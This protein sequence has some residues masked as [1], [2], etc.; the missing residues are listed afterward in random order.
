MSGPGTRDV[1]IGWPSTDL[2]GMQVIAENPLTIS[3]SAVG[4]TNAGFTAPEIARAQHMMVYFESGAIRFR[5]DGTAVT[6]TTGDYTDFGIEWMQAKTNYKG[7]IANLSMIRDND[8]TD[9]VSAW[10][11]LYN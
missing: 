2:A 11:S 10:I 7:W 3:T 6:N 5:R 1:D 8:E 4:L 9:D